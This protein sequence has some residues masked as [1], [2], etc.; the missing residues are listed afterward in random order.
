MRPELIYHE[1]LDILHVNNLPEHNYYIPFAPSQDPFEE[2]EASEFFQLLNGQWDFAYFENAGDIPDLE[3]IVFERTIPVPSN[4]QLHGCDKPQYTNVRYPIP[5]DPPFVPED[6][7]AG[8]YR[9]FY[10]YTP[11]GMKR[12]LAF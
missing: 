10:S 1:N 12:T 3:N 11:D 2:R 4:W 7:P 9:T 8:V 5:F 6:N